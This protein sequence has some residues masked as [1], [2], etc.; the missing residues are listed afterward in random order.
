MFMQLPY[1]FRTHQTALL[2]RRDEQRVHV[3]LRLIWVQKHC[4]RLLCLARA[5]IVV[6][7]MTSRFTRWSAHAVMYV[8]YS[9]KSLK[10]SYIV[11]I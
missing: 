5:H 2:M 8:A 1:K 9:F 4:L 11:N 3:W 7:K 6:Y 10:P